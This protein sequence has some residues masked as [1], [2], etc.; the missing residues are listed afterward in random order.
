MRDVDAARQPPSNNARCWWGAAAREGSVV[1]DWMRGAGGGGGSRRGSLLCWEL[2]EPQGPKGLHLA[3]L[4][5]LGRD[6]FEER[7][8]RGAVGV[9]V[10]HPVG[11][12]LLGG[13]EGAGRFDDISVERRPSPLVSL[14]SR[15]PSPISVELRLLLDLEAE[16]AE[17][18]V[19]CID[20]TLFLPWGETWRKEGLGAST[21]HAV[22]LVGARVQ[23]SGNAARGQGRAGASNCV[24]CKNLPSAGER[25]ERKGLV[26]RRGSVDAENCIEIFAPPSLFKTGVPKGHRPGRGGDKLTR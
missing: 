21:C 26:H 10:L 14:V 17:G 24:Y 15:V 16:L 1:F 2:E 20:V 8:F 12:A 5:H 11:D 23:G 13:R 6:G 7:L 4:R 3:L 9:A 19:E 18:R 22:D 25:G